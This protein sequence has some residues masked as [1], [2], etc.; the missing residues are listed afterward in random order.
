M[1]L[2]CPELFGHIFIY[3]IS[4]KHTIHS[5]MNRAS[6]KYMCAIVI[7]CSFCSAGFPC[8]NYDFRKPC[9]VD[10]IFSF[11]KYLHGNF[12]ILT[13]NPATGY[14]TTDCAFCRPW[15]AKGMHVTY[16]FS[17]II[18]KSRHKTNCLS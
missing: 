14:L 18:M 17:Y 8:E 11:Q 3:S 9:L 1:H 13:Q 10:F 15:C 12:S 7:H 2:T 16:F 4:I 6:S 5:T